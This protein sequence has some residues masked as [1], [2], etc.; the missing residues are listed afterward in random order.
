MSINSTFITSLLDYIKK[1]ELLMYLRIIAYINN[2]NP[3]DGRNVITL[4]SG[5]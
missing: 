4:A 1:K 2:F 3:I 5:P